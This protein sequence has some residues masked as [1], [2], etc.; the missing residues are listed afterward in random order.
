M[1]QLQLRNL[2]GI[3]ILDLIDMERSSMR[4]RVCT[5]FLDA[6]KR[7]RAKTN[8]SKI[9]GFELIEMTRKRARLALTQRL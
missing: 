7:D 5:T 6:L 4:H 8:V 3:I 9:S 2:G 1:H